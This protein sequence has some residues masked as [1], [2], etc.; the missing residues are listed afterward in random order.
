VLYTAA[1]VVGAG[2]PYHEREEYQVC[3][4]Y[5]AVVVGN[6]EDMLLDLEEGVGIDSAVAVLELVQR[7]LQ[8]QK[9]VQQR[10]VR[11]RKLGLLLRQDP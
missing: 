4:P 9:V 1:A 6:L 2:T 11:Q 7:A 10:P 8:A 3:Q 5:E